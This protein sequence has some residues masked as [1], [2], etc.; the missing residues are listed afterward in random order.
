[1]NHQSPPAWAKSMMEQLKQMEKRVADLVPKIDSLKASDKSA[2][3]DSHRRG[4]SRRGLS[5]SQIADD[6]QRTPKARQTLL[7]DAGTY[8]D[9]TYRHPDTEYTAQTR[10]PTTLPGSLHHH[11]GS[12]HGGLQD[13]F[14]DDNE[15]EGPG[16]PAF[17]NRTPPTQDG[18]AYSRH[19]DPLLNDRGESPGQQFLE[20]ELYK[21]RVRQPSRSAAT[22]RSW[23]IARE[24]QD[25]DHEHGDHALTES[26]MEPL[27]MPLDA[28]G[29]PG[30]PPLPPIPNQDDDEVGTVDGQQPQPW[31]PA[32]NPEQPSLP[33]WQRIHQKLLSWAIVWPMSELDGALNSTLRGQQVDEVALSIWSTQQYKRYVRNQLTE[34]PTKKVDRLFVPPNIADAINNA[35]FHGRH[36]DAC[37]MLRDLWAPFGLDGLPRLIIVLCKHRNDANHWVAHK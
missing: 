4:S 15:T 35:V 28:S 1:M 14:E 23:E 32:Y 18:D 16:R 27:D 10:D 20:E 5:A 11:D 21:L 8:R 37:A 24:D 31:A 17:S 6:Y 12:S 2:R 26:G 13:E 33:P 34:Y 7:D 19:R 36:G 29:R 9:S 22:H 3:S 30:S 25:E